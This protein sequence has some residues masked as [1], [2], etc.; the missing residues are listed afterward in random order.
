MIKN[1]KAW[2][3]IVEAFIAI[4]LIFAV[5]ITLYTRQVYRAD[6]SEEVYSL[7]KAILGQISNNEDLRINVLNKN[8]ES[9][10]NFLEDKIPP[11][12]DYTIRICELNEVCSM[13]FYQ[14]EVY[15]SETVISSTLQEYSPKVIKIFMWRKA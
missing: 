10:L 9:I 2:V 7:Q 11:S 6:I 12:L 14:T 13:D 4:T 5:F 15:A 8:N 3:K 1:K